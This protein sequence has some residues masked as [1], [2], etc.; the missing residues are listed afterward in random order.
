[1]YRYLISYI[2][3]FNG[4]GTNGNVEVTRPD[5]IRDM[6]DITDLT[7]ELRDHFGLNRPIIMGFSRFEEEAGR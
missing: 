4:G 1:M 6:N 2:D 7:R 3:P 5:P